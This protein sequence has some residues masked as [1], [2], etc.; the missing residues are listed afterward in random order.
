MFKKYYGFLNQ[1]L[2]KNKCSENYSCD[3]NISLERNTKATI[4]AAKLINKFLHFAFKEKDLETTKGLHRGKGLK[5]PP[6]APF[7]ILFVRCFP[8]I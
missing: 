2:S 7:C 8:N 6:S 1:T 5:S 4:Q 3:F